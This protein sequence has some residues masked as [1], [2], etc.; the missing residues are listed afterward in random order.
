MHPDAVTVLTR[1][2]VVATGLAHPRPPLKRHGRDNKLHVWKSPS[3]TPSTVRGSA[4]APPDDAD[5]SAA[6]PQ[7]LTR[8]QRAQLLPL[9]APT[10]RRVFAFNDDDDR[11]ACVR[12]RSEP[13]RVVTGSENPLSCYRK[14]SCDDKRFFFPLLISRC[15]G[16]SVQGKNTCRYRKRQVGRLDDSRIRR[17]GCQEPNRYVP[18]DGW[19]RTRTHEPI[20]PLFLCS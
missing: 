2:V 15:M 8:R 10:P 4:S 13:S 16:P 17:P 9:F 11:V 12:G 19:I 18:H 6:D 3:Q 7:L 20:P 1:R 5:A 14:S